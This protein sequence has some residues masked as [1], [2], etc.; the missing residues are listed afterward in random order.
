MPRML[1]PVL[2][3][4]ESRLSP[5][6]AIRPAVSLTMSLVVTTEV[7]V[8]LGFLAQRVLGQYEL[9]LL[10]E[11]DAE[12]PPRLLFVLPNL[13][14]AVGSLDAPEDEFLT[15]VTLHAGVPWLQSYLA[16]L[17]AELM[18]SAEVRMD[19]PRRLRL[20]TRAQLARSLQAARAGDVVGIFAS[21]GERATL[22][23]VQAARRSAMQSSSAPARPRSRTCSPLRR[24]CR[25]WRRS[26][27]R[28]GGSRGPPSMHRFWEQRTTEA[29]P[30]VCPGLEI[31]ADGQSH[32]PDPVRSAAAKQAAATRK[33][34]A[35][36]QAG[37]RVSGDAKRTA[38]DARRGA[39]RTRA[40][41]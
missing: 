10:D 11:P 27:I 28:R 17:V 13:G 21:P 15:W 23:R 19:A 26:P 1:G 40:T 30:F 7:G 3:R 18:R 31:R 5:S 33:R 39:N 16:G 9:V 41:R 36:R 22:D 8:V 29:V 32:T 38:T 35:A 34:T 2:E 20:P 24:R 25:R 37:T 14:A 4:A 12:R 6:R